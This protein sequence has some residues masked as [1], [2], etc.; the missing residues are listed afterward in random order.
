MMKVMGMNFGKDAAGTD[1]TTA[2]EAMAEKM[3]TE[4][5]AEKPDPKAIMEAGGE[6]MTTYNDGCG[7]AELLCCGQTEE[8]GVWSDDYMCNTKTEIELDS[9]KFRCVEGATYVAA[10]AMSLVAAAFMMA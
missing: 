4:M 1:M 9:L 3:K 7:N 2:F 6:G 10:G 5:A 8:F